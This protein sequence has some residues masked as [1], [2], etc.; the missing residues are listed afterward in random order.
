MMQDQG[1]YG[2]TI[3]LERN[4]SKHR[5][6]NRFDGGE[7]LPRSGSANSATNSEGAPLLKRSSSSMYNSM[8]QR[9]T[10]IPSILEHYGL[11]D[12][13]QSSALGLDDQTIR[14]QIVVWYIGKV[15]VVQGR[16]PMT[17]RITMFWNDP[18]E[19]DEFDLP[20]PTADTASVGACSTRTQRTTWT[21][22]GRQ[23]AFQK[24]IKDVPMKAIDV[25]PVS[26]LNVVSFDIVG[27]PEV[28][29]L[30]EDTRLMRWSCM[31][32]A[33]L[34]QENMRVDRFPHD[35]HNLYLKL[36]ILAHRGRG[37]RWDR[38]LWKLAL[39][40]EEDSQGSTRIPHGLVVDQVNIP[41]FHHDK[42]K[43]LEFELVPLPHG[44][45][46]AS[47]TENG[48]QCLEVKLS[49]QRDSGYYDKNI[50]PLLV[51]LNTVAISIL[52]LDASLYFQRALLT[53]NIA[54]VQISIRMTVDSHL[55]NV[56]YQI[57]M[58]RLLNEFFCGLLCLVLEGILVYAL[59]HTYGWSVQHTSWID[60]LVA[61]AASF[62][63]VYR[64]ISFY[65]ESYRVSRDVSKG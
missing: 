30:R 3:I 64:S 39:A 23:Q 36:G 37:S 40:T 20:L 2:P 29:M 54:F 17:F 52:W 13:R 59:D 11:P 61:C 47:Q 5:D 6:L 31:Y 15:D 45:V 38:N 1:A 57:K 58:Q 4:L 33:T 21:M 16:V 25:P 7:S 44:T 34:I 12:G 49:V 55:P 9:S 62:H 19:N 63:L 50:M 53:L 14:F 65:S 28:S 32:R 43:G 27:S 60:L 8:G 48:E 26:I 46:A 56:G 41:D 42:E 18:L 22:H 24:E 10:S 51:L 35:K